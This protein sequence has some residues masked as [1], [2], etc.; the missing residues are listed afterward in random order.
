MEY[1]SKQRELVIASQTVSRKSEIYLS[2]VGSGHI[3]RNSGATDTQGYDTDA[4]KNESVLKTDVCVTSMPGRMSSH[5]D[6]VTNLHVHLQEVLL[7]ILELCSVTGKFIVTEYTRDEDE[8]HHSHVPPRMLQ[9]LT[10]CIDS[11]SI[12]SAPAAAVFSNVT[13]ESSL[14]SAKATCTSVYILVVGDQLSTSS[15]ATSPIDL[16]TDDQKHQEPCHINDN[17]ALSLKSFVE[18]VF[19]SNLDDALL[20]ITKKQEDNKQRNRRRKEEE[21]KFTTKDVLA[22]SGVIFSSENDSECLSSGGSGQPNDTTEVLRFGE[23]S[24]KIK[25]NRRMRRF[26][27]GKSGR[28]SVKQGEQSVLETRVASDN[29]DDDDWGNTRVGVG[30]NTSGISRPIVGDSRSPSPLLH[31][32]YEVHEHFVILLPLN[33]SKS[34]VMS[35]QHD[36]SCVPLTL[37]DI[38][39][40]SRVQ[41]KSRIVIT[42]LSNLPSKASNVSTRD[43]ALKTE[44]EVSRATVRVSLNAG[45]AVSSNITKKKKGKNKHVTLTMS[46][47][48]FVHDAGLRGQSIGL[49]RRHQ[50]SSFIC[51][52]GSTTH[53][54]I[55]NCQFRDLLSDE[56]SSEISMEISSGPWTSKKR[57]YRK[58]EALASS[59]VQ[60]RNMIS[61]LSGCSLVMHDACI[62]SQGV[63]CGVHAGGKARALLH[64]CKVMNIPHGCGVKCESGSQVEL[65]HCLVEGCGKSGLFS[66]D[67]LWVS[68]KQCEMRD[69]GHCG[70]EVF[71][72]H[73]ATQ[74]H[75]V[76][77]GLEIDHCTISCNRSSGVLVLNCTDS[78]ISSSS[79]G[80]NNLSNISAVSGTSCQ[81]LDCDISGSKRSGIYASDCD[82][83]VEVVGG[84][85][86]GNSSG[87]VECQ[88]N[89]AVIIT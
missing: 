17:G 27:A 2:K 23:G 1:I 60:Q 51:G 29:D 34:F 62:S 32:I 14:P 12:Q 49:P 85:R 56:S 72:C 30:G 77:T 31:H 16:L 20:F 73:R 36:F 61:S 53:V 66:R 19:V 81:V 59:A 6:D 89:A 11:M 38:S 80:T 33:A 79:I 39:A 22:S 48:S 50:N 15:L 21:V 83:R 84:R 76:K 42:T 40:T 82:T 58:E 55:S 10:E 7:N 44:L 67:S 71:S 26:L 70:V 13:C 28:N 5:D 68:L 4:K 46:N 41:Y 65:L 69:N 3:P 75:C 9:D 74:L 86:Y 78:T 37:T 43:D 87:N 25:L 64:K 47:I 35:Q 63:V 24:T 57:K 45:I 54:V 88:L 52:K 8:V 18:R